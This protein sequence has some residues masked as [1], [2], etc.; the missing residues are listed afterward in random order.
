MPT[1]PYGLPKLAAEELV[2]LYAR[3]Y[4]VPVTIL[5][6]FT[7]YGSR[8][9]PEMRLSRFIYEHGKSFVSWR[10]PARVLPAIWRESWAPERLTPLSTSQPLSLRTSPAA[11]RKEYR[12]PPSA[13]KAY[14]DSDP[15][16][17]ACLVPQ[18]LFAEVEL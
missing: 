18:V 3:E 1:S 12:R 4:A 14:L 9:R 8:Q 6:Y 17:D 16:P 5:R 11:S 10:Y 13:S 2:G 7:V 15:A